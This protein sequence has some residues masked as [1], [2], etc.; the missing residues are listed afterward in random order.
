M[1]GASLKFVEVARANIQILGLVLYYITIKA[2][3]DDDQ[4]NNAQPKLYRAK[5]VRHR[6]NSCYGQTEADRKYTLECFYLSPQQTLNR[7]PKP[8]LKSSNNKKRKTPPTQPRY[9][10]RSRRPFY[11]FV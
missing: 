1:Q 11:N 5:V 3:D 9:M 6:I 10:P 4:Q 7:P 2:I 8:K